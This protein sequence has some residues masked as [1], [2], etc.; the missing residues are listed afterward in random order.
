M[1]APLRHWSFSFPLSPCVQTS[2]AAPHLATFFE[3]N[4][5]QRASPSHGMQ[6]AE[7]SPFLFLLRSPCPS[8]PI[9]PSSGFGGNA[10]AHPRDFPLQNK[11]DLAPLQILLMHIERGPPFSP[12]PFSSRL[13]LVYHL[14]LVPLLR[15]DEDCSE[16]CSFSAGK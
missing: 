5:P 6:L 16:C 12:V 14:V 7:I 4:M 11:G 9:S 8:A 15:H 3:Q 13:Q 2:V 10:P 1:R